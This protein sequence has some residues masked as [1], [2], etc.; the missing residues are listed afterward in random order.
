MDL[1][2]ETEATGTGEEGTD[3]RE[4]GICGIYTEELLE[5]RLKLVS[6]LWDA[7]IKVDV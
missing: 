7:K 2:R 6:E 4:T 1:Y 3:Q 5:E